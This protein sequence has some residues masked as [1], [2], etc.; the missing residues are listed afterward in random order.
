MPSRK[1]SADLEFRFTEADI[2][3]MNAASGPHPLSPAAYLKFLSQF[4]ATYEQLRAKQGPWGERFR[5]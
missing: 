2:R 4:K 3:A 5:L 1:Q